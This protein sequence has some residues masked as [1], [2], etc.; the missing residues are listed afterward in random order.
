MTKYALRK[1]EIAFAGPV[2][3]RSGYGEWADELAKCLINYDKANITILPEAWGACVSRR[4]AT[5]ADELIHSKISKTRQINQPDVLITCNMPYLNPLMGRVFNINFCA[6]LEVDRCPDY[7]MEGINRWDLCVVM[8]QFAKAGYLNSAIKPIPPIDILPWGQDTNIFRVSDN[9]DQYVDAEIAK[10]EEPEIFL[11]VGQIT[12]PHLFADRKNMAHLIR[13]FCETFKHEPRKPALLLKT[14]GVNFSNFDRDATITKIQAA[15]ST[16]KTNDVNV[17][18]LHGELT[19]NQMACLYNH[20][21]IIS[22][23]SFTRGEGWGGPLLQASL[24]GKPVIAPNYSGHLEFLPQGYFIPLAGNLQ[25]IPESGISQ[26]FIKGSKWYEVDYDKAK[27][28]MLNFFYGEREEINKKA[29][30]LA[31]I[32]SEKF[33]LPAM[34]RQFHTL[35]DKY[36]TGK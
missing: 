5:A 34:Q 30:E 31:K 24:A 7:F 28:T 8:S 29:L 15:K 25:E 6:G 32:N 2:L 13:V 35:L 27:D 36:L 11:C 20:P 12:S 9:R 22:N 1:F 4:I 23:I 10:I 21:R 16:V 3:N 14:S 17:Y 18:L 26:F 33:S 19:N